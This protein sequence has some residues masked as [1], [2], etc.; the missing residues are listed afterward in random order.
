MSTTEGAP[1]PIPT[2]DSSTPPPTPAATTTDPPTPP[3][4]G[5]PGDLAAEVEKWKQLARKN[6]DRAKA[7]ATAA[8][9]LAQLR[10]QSMSETE[11]AVAV[12][13][14]EGVTEAT[15]AL[16]ARLV[17]AEVRAAAAGRPE[18]QVDALL[19]GMDAAKFIGDDGEPDVRAIKAWVGKTLPEADPAGT[20]TSSPFPDLGQGARP[21]ASASP[22]AEFAAF[23]NRQ[24][25][26]G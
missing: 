16:G 19:E 10:Q 6:E 5:A 11:R 8:T 14:A 7:N 21:G 20:P 4:T 24:L 3:A 9:E 18:A 15:R 22:Q 23:L 13:R 12:A 25:N 17:S 26:E 1:A 2:T